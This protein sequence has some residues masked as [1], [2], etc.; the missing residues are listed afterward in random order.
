M[1]DVPGQFRRIR[2]RIRQQA[3]DDVPEQIRKKARHTF[4]TGRAVNKEVHYKKLLAK[5]QQKVQKA[6]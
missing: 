4:L 5:D 1:D 2:D 3:L 6:M